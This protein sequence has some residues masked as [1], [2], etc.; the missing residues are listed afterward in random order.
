V[1]NVVELVA[2][3]AIIAFVIGASFGV[4]IIVAAGIKAEE[5]VARRRN[6][7]R[8]RATTLYDEPASTMTRGVRW[9]TTGR[10]AHR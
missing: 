1:A 6:R 5:N 4:I 3:V 8:Q 10:D 9:V 2:V 7:A